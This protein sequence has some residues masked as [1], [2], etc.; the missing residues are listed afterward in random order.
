MLQLIDIEEKFAGKLYNETQL[1]YQYRF[2][3]PFFQR[4]TVHLQV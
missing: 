1:T 4:K 3:V 2:A